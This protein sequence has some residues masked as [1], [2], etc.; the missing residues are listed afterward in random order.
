MSGRRRYAPQVVWSF[1]A[2]Y[3]YL[4]I[5]TYF[6]LSEFGLY[7]YIFVTLFC[8]SLNV[9]FLLNKLQVEEKPEAGSGCVAAWRKLW[10]TWRRSLQQGSLNKRGKKG[11][12][13]KK[14]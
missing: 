9:L 1:L 11:V 2:Q 12:F 8:V 4:Y 10:Q 7:I 5:Y 14:C 13:W 3:D 6:I